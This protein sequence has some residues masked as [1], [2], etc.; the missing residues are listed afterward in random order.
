MVAWIV[1]AALSLLAFAVVGR[2]ERRLF[3]LLFVVVMLAP[4]AFDAGVGRWVIDQIPATPP[5][6]T[7]PLPPPATTTPGSGS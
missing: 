1:F 6:T 3:L 2:A 7:T 5:T 4:A